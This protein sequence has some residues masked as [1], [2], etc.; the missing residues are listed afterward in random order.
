MSGD[1]LGFA[2]L[3]GR[4]DE[5]KESLEKSIQYAQALDCKKYVFT[6][7]LYLLLHTHV[8]ILMTLYLDSI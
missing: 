8:H 3:P 7:K 4:Q 5:F 1:K 2:A 6:S